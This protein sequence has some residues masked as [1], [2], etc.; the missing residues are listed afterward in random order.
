MTVS[1]QITGNL[2]SPVT[3]ALDSTSET[4]VFEPATTGQYTVIAI[5][6]ANVD[7]SNACRATVRWSDGSTSN[8]MFTD[9]VAAGETIMIPVVPIPLFPN[10]TDGNGAAKKIT[11]QAENADD[12]VVTVIATLASAVRADANYAGTA[13]FR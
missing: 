7:T 4:D 10:A 13:G 11:A 2:Q 6:V 9:S 5:A 3:T 12:L 1:F 8:V